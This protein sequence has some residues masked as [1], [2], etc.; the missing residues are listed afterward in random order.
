MH[1]A[2]WGWVREPWELIEAGDVSANEHH[3]HASSL[4]EQ[5]GRIKGGVTTM[6]DKRGPSLDYLCYCLIMFLCGSCPWVAAA[7]LL[8]L[9]VYFSI[10]IF[11]CLVVPASF[12]YQRTLLH[13]TNRSE[14]VKTS[15]S[16][17][18]CEKFTIRCFSRILKVSF[19]FSQNPMWW[20]ICRIF[21]VLSQ[22]KNI[23]NEIAMCF[24]NVTGAVL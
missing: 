23:R 18:F 12:P 10:K 8:F 6:K 21:L 2:G 1:Y 19:F 7:L 9:F 17:L 15:N 5:F 14:S 24:T 3:L 4:T 16:I 13:S 22:N 20:H 11:E